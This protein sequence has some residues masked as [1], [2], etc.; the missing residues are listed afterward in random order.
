[1]IQGVISAVNF[2]KR[3]LNAVKSL[4][5]GIMP[6]GG[7]KKQVLSFFNKRKNTSDFLTFSAMTSGFK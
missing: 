1:M 7:L 4:Y 6:G 3:S 5:K 2:V